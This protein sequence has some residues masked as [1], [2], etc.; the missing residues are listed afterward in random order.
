[1]ARIL[2]NPRIGVLVAPA[3]GTQPKMKDILGVYDQM[4]YDTVLKKYLPALKS[5]L[6]G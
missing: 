4:V 6:P 2:V 1:M 3:Q 5:D